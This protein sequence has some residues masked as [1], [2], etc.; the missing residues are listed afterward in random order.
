MFYLY[1]NYYTAEQG[2]PTF[3]KLGATSCVP[4][5]AKGCKF[6]THFKNKNFAQFTFNYFS[7][8]IR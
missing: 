5:Y 4:I 3:L 6:D 2:S 8:D 7:I 1:S